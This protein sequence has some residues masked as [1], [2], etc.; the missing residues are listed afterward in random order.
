MPYLIE[1]PHEEYFVAKCQLS[2]PT[3]LK[4]FFFSFTE[5]VSLQHYGFLGTV[6]GMKVPAT[7]HLTVL[8]FYLCNSCVHFKI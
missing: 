6:M 3:S 7:N 8:V 4:I 1:D 2:V 5:F